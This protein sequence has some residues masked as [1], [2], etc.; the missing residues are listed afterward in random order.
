VLQLWNH[1]KQQ[2]NVQHS[3]S[4]M[5]SAQWQANNKEGIEGID[6]K[7]C[8]WSLTRHHPASLKSAAVSEVV[9]EI[10]RDW[11]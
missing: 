3:N 4:S 10:V 9:H 1:H 7:S 5:E 2:H 11:V 6:R 8:K